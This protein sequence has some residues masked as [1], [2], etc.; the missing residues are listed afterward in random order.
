MLQSIIQNLGGTAQLEDGFCLGEFDVTIDNETRVKL[1]KPI[2][3]TLKDHCVD[4]LWLFPSS[5]FKGLILCPPENVRLYKKSALESLRTSQGDD[6]IENIFRKFISPCKSAN[7]GTQG[8]ISLNRACITLAEF[9][10]GDSVT[11]LGFGCWYEVWHENDYLEHI[12]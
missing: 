2:L 3:N 8:R 1:S 5:Y 9:E 7:V 11:I 6:C 10:P 4:N 12:Q